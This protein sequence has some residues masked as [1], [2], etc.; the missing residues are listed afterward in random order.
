MSLRIVLPFLAVVCFAQPFV[1]ARADDDSVAG[2]RTAPAADEM[3]ARVDELLEQRLRQAGVQPSP[4]AA[5]AVFLRRAWLDLNGVIPSGSEVSAYVNDTRADK[6]SR[7]I[8]R[9][10]NHPRH[11]THM[12][13]VWSAMLLP[14]N[15]QMDRPAE[16]AG[17][18]TW[19]R[20][21]FAENISYD[22]I[23]AELLTT[24]G[25]S[26]R[27]GAALFYTATG[28]KPEEL[29]ASTSRIFLGVQIHC[30][31]CHNHPFDHW[32]QDDFW[33]Y[34]A[35]FA[36]VQLASG[37][38][39]A[40][41]QMPSDVRL[42]DAA[43][44]EVMLPGGSEPI[45]PKYLGADPPR[46]DADRNRRRQLALWLVS[47][48]NPYFSQVAVNRVWAMLFGRGLVHPVD[49]FGAQNP[50][51]HPELLAELATYFSD[52]GYDLK[53]LFRVLVATRAYQ[54]SSESVSEGQP[55]AELF[56]QM[57]VKTLSPDQLYDCLLKAVR[58]DE[59]AA[60]PTTP[61]EPPDM[62]AV[63]RRQFTAR[64]DMGTREPTEFVAG[65]PQVLA[66]MNGAITAEATDPERGGLLLA[67]AA[68]FFSDDERVAALFLAVLSREPTPEERS[69]FA[70]YLANSASPDDRREALGDML[71]AM[72]NSPEFVLNH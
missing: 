46:E 37:N 15:A 42:I 68:P 48:D 30:A 29:A 60:S 17:F 51:S 49:E 24:T 52:N 58:R 19:L 39:P 35:F 18:T 54:R 28:L 57:Q 11:A 69:Q 12:A 50:P 59:P 40:P 38:Q 66:L 14:A 36:R 4:P 56:A 72:L 27:G 31:Q 41:G 71:W 33:S 67:L 9:L 23:V 45:S 16:V 2:E 43:E 7:L 3:S 62:S 25:N 26:R 1:A 53:G 44:G 6:Q 64:F 34:A 10:L 5:D 63:S 61:G 32:R 47:R 13:R 21:R 65:I 22:N 55:A 70:A 8:D 20:H